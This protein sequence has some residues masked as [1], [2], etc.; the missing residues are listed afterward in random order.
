[1]CMG[2][3]AIGQM[4]GQAAD[5]IVGGITSIHQGILERSAYRYQRDQAE[6]QAQESIRIGAENEKA[7]RQETEQLKGRQR[8]GFGAS[9]A[10]VDTGTPGDILADT[11]YFGEDDALTIRHNAAVQANSFTNQARQYEFQA[12][13]AM[14]AG[15]AKGIYSFIHPLGDTNKSMGGMTSGIGQ[16]GTTQLTSSPMTNP[17]R[18]ATSV[19]GFMGSTSYGRFSNT[20]GSANSFTPSQSLSETNS[21]QYSPYSPSVYNASNGIGL[22]KKY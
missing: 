1:M 14:N 16:Q 15:L 8:A 2:G 7:K 5:G 22:P 9:G 4:A 19:N 17:G 3:M 18:S 11:A 10:V 20:Y 12:K 21:S 6:W 13:R